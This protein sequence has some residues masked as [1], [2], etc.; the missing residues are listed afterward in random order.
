MCQPRISG[1]I[2]LAIIGAVFLG[3]VSLFLLTI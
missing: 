1:E 2:I 3:F